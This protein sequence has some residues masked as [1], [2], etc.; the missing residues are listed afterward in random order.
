MSN[1][2]NIVLQVLCNESLSCI[3]DEVSPYLRKPSLLD[4][5][6]VEYSDV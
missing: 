2:D 4:K 1:V 6:V 5:M 3:H